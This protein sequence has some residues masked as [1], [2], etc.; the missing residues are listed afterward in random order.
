L[1]I[2]DAAF[3]ASFVVTPFDPVAI[4]EVQSAATMAREHYRRKVELILPTAKNKDILRKV[5]AMH[6]HGQ[7]Q[8]DTRVCFLNAAGTHSV[9]HTL[10]KIIL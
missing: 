10:L 1:A 6:L 5:A 4:D 3:C 2:P 8:V 9:L 7:L